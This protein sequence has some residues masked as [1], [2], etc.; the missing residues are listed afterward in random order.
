MGRDT[1]QRRASSALSPA[2][3]KLLQA[4]LAKAKL[5]SVDDLRIPERPP[6]ARFPATPPQRRFWFIDELN[7]GDPAYNMHFAVELEGELDAD[8][9][10]DAL[11]AVVE[12]HEVLRS[13]FTFE[14]D[15]LY[16]EV[17]EDRVAK[18][19]RHARS[20]FSEPESFLIRL[21]REPFSLSHGPLFRAELVELAVNKHVLLLVLHHIICDEPSIAILVREIA[22]LYGDPAA[23]GDDTAAP[24][25]RFADYA[26]WQRERLPDVIRDQ[27]PYWTEALAGLE[28]RTSVPVDN[29]QSGSGLATGR[30][31]RSKLDARLVDKARSI[32]A[33]ER[34]TL[35]SVMLATWSALLSR[36]T[37]HHDVAVGT[38]VSLRTVNDL[39]G[40]VGLFLNTLVLRTPV[41]P[42]KSFHALLRCARETVLDAFSHQEVPLESIVEAVNPARGQGE[43]P[44]FDTMVVQEDSEGSVDGFGKLAASH[45][46][47]D[48][49]VCKFD[50]TLFFRETADG[51][52]LSIEYDTSLYEQR[53][54]EAVLNHFAGLLQS[55]LDDPAQPVG[56]AEYLR[57]EEI[58]WLE[59]C[60]VGRW[61]DVGDT[62]TVAEQ[63]E[64][65]LALL[66]QRTAVID[67][68]G[69]VSYHELNRLVAGM[70]DALA[71]SDRPPRCVVVLLERSRWAIAAMLAAWRSGACYVPLD[72]NYPAARV[73]DAL[74]ALT[75]SE[76]RDY[77]VVT[78]AQSRA[79][80]PDDTP[81][82]LIDRPRPAVTS[83]RTPKKS[84]PNDAP[85]YVIFT[86]GSSGRPKGV[87]VTHENLR[88][89]NGAREIV[90]GEHPDSYLL[91]SPLP[92]DSSVAG[93]YW[94]LVGGGTLV[95]ADQQQARDCQQIARLVEQ[96]SISHTLLLPSMYEL[97]LATAEESA[98]RSLRT[99][100]VAG[101][102]CP[103]SLHASHTSSVPQATLYNEYGP[104][105]ATVWATVQ[106]VNG[107]DSAVPIGSSIPSVRAYV[108]DAQGQLQAPGMP[109]ELCL[110]GP[111]VSPGYLAGNSQQ[112]FIRASVFG[113]EQRL[114]RTGDAAYLDPQGRIIFV[115][116]ID[117]QVKVRGYRVE[118][119]E[120]N[121]A[122]RRQF[123][124][125]DVATTFDPV[126][127]SL[128]TFI[129][130]NAR[131]ASP[132]AVMAKLRAT[133]PAYMVPQQV[134]V[135]DDLPRLPNG[136]VDVAMLP[137][138]PERFNE[139]EPDDDTYRAVKA[140]WCEALGVED[141]PHDVGFFDL[142]GHS[143]AAARMI[144]K[145]QDVVGSQC[146][147]S[148]IY[149]NQTLQE[150]YDYLSQAYSGKGQDI[151]YPARP[152]G[153]ETP[154]FAVKTY[155]N[156]LLDLI[157]PD[158]PVFGLT[159]GRKAPD[160]TISSVEA[161]AA[162]YLDAARRQQRK[163]P[164]RFVGY[165]F[166]AL[167]A[168]EMAHQVIAAGDE[169]ELLV[170][171]DPPPPTP[172]GDTRFRAT[173]TLNRIRAAG[174]S[175][176]KFQIAVAEMR[177]IVRRR[178]VNLRFRLVRLA[179]R[180]LRRR[181]NS[182]VSRWAG[183]DWESGARRAY[184]HKPYPGRTLL[185]LL[186]REGL[187]TDE[188]QLARWSGILSGDKKVEVIHGPADHVGL[189]QPPW[190]AQVGA[191]LNAALSGAR[192]EKTTAK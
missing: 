110:A 7:P 140:V 113:E 137:A 124:I 152:N 106:K 108:L 149:E 154:V 165:S 176:G 81:C 62:P 142:G 171:I 95:V 170:L 40:T 17:S 169:V 122:V 96:H 55:V 56:K 29:R 70:A 131:N 172:E 130:S 168:I 174:S 53:R 161:L 94:T 10:Q 89:S 107:V 163:G 151:L 184:K 69:S 134:L 4:R 44:F 128:R 116:R 28:E 123:D 34:T 111:S 46:W 105:E 153:T 66:D 159:H 58:E 12:R 160:E 42:A 139:D 24:R 37:G 38:P 186:G 125:Q 22:E 57:Q 74:D 13:R 73:A 65:N 39:D 177:R 132:D 133:L 3:Q 126:S 21:S 187:E 54:I 146:P 182:K 33:E 91:L 117:D 183:N 19:R 71:G 48:A 179:T 23:K 82:L 166:G 85:A 60:S 155:L 181:T 8:R 77:V 36:Y 1:K 14:G 148:A 175:A 144:L 80:L 5:S 49:C 162:R 67:N 114:Y 32:A 141:T 180:L 2:K 188:R 68:K 51:M 61:Q 147:L 87:V 129:V 191:E 30:I 59:H 15:E 64:A 76:L 6:V 192:R 185:L 150:F 158:V 18:L 118:L 101:E 98:L 9:L 79:L 26:H 127:Q 178:I 97:V 157:A 138:K 145:L 93:I 16:Q 119:E 164:Y 173:R 143:L 120:V 112:A 121:A 84:V 72:P 63:V 50:L 75:A 52:L 104:S 11:N 90:Y 43:N 99:V 103:E 102:A 27:L 156:Y 47:V 45:H 88:I 41:D 86:S 83:G 190:V 20:S 167:L 25:T 92:F 189:M 78:T 35:L 135:L 100:I 136:K 115:G 31:I 109:G